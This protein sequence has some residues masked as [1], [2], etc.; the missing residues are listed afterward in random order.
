MI[1][2]IEWRLRPR[3]QIGVCVGEGGGSVLTNGIKRAACWMQQCIGVI[4]SKSQSRS[5]ADAVV[6]PD[7][8]HLPFAFF[9]RDILR[10]NLI[11][12]LLGF[13]F[14]LSENHSCSDR[15]GC[16]CCCCCNNQYL[17]LL[18][19]EFSPDP[20]GGE[21]EESLHLWAT[22]ELL[23]VLKIQCLAQR[24]FSTHRCGRQN[25]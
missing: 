5:S 16:C 21:W 17:L 25:A 22:G 8:L 10:E 14:R 9:L 2:K 12:T 18:F 4:P 20:F 24:H 15:S 23:C 1:V 19:G 11:F 7:T 13:E 3:L 6:I